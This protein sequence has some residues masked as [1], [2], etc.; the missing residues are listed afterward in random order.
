M[1][2]LKRPGHCRC[3]NTVDM[4]T[5]DVIYWTIANVEGLRARYFFQPLY[6]YMYMYVV[7]DGCRVNIYYLL[8]AQY[9]SLK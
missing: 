4:G 3:A 7:L 9:G 8:K 5:V 2:F 6:M 1:L